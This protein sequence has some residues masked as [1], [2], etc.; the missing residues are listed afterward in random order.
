MKKIPGVWDFEDKVKQIVEE[1]K[2]GGYDLDFDEVLG[3]EYNENDRWLEC[4]FDLKYDRTMI[5]KEFF[6]SNI[7]TVDIYS[8]TVDDAYTRLNIKSANVLGKQYMPKTIF[9]SHYRELYECLFNLLT[10]EKIITKKYKN[11][12]RMVKISSRRP[13]CTDFYG[14]LL[15]VG[16]FRYS[17]YGTYAIVSIYN[18]EGEPISLK[19]KIIPSF[20]L[21]NKIYNYRHRCSMKIDYKETIKRYA[22][23]IGFSDNPLVIFS[24]KEYSAEYYIVIPEFRDLSKVLTAVAFPSRGEVEIAAANMDDVVILNAREGNAYDKHGIFD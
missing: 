23:S 2:S 1:V 12:F 7:S 3:M 4:R 17:E 8:E 19:N 18:D 5:Y 16:W 13:L 20:H 6:S 21:V 15:G 11:V 24:C 10:K 14:S 9:H 22:K